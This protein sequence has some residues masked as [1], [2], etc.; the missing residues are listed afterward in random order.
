[1]SGPSSPPSS[2]A[3]P[4]TS[5]ASRPATASPPSTAPPP[6]RCLPAGARSTGCPAAA[7]G[8]STTPST[9][10]QSPRSAPH[11]PGRGYYD[12]KIAEGKTRKEAL[13]A[14]KRRISDALTAMV[15]DARRRTAPDSEGGPGRATGERL[16]RQRGRLT[17]RD[18]GSSA[19]PLP[20]P[21]QGYDHQDEPATRAPTD[22]QR[23]P[24][25]LLDKQRGLDRHSFRPHVADGVANSALSPEPG[26]RAGLSGLGYV[27]FAGHPATR[28]RW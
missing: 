4:V 23:R 5:P 18:T 26:S 1:M 24:E 8:T 28:Q 22:A 15:A 25:E 6:S 27:H 9:W 20:N 10:P 17:P 13:R 12:R 14:L 21:H 16:C 3:S 2:S 19:K 11:S 7:T